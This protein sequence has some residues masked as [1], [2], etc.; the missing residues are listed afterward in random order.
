LFS[1]LSR[2]FEPVALLI[3]AECENHAMA[4]Q[5]S[6]PMVIQG[7]ALMNFELITGIRLNCSC[8]FIKYLDSPSDVKKKKSHVS[9]KKTT[10]N[11][12]RINTEFLLFFLI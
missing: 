11:S 4:N 10:G 7:T 5:T 2:G 6:T 3:I 1:F 12:I 8:S 9:S